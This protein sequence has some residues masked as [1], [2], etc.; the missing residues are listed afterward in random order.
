MELTFKPIGAPAYGTAF[1]S[2]IAT[3]PLKDLGTANN[4]LPLFV[5]PKGSTIVA[6]KLVCTEDSNGA[7]TIDIGTYN[8]TN[9]AVGTAID[10][11]AL[12]AAAA[13]ATTTK[14]GDL[15]AKAA[16]AIGTQVTADVVVQASAK[17]VTE[18]SVPTKGALQLEV[19]TL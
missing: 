7:G 2:Y 17:T 12:Y 14:V 5:V 15:L 9:G 6:V 4:T 1:R 10:A 8:I 16:T 19:V 13:Y 3:I 18:G 11:D